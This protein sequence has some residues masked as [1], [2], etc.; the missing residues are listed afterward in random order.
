M[1]SLTMFGHMYGTCT[2]FP[3]LAL[4]RYIQTCLMSSLAVADIASR[5][6][7]RRHRSG[8]GKPITIA[9]RIV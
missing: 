8:G 1:A 9:T 3:K 7:A 2:F 4:I 5:C 6:L